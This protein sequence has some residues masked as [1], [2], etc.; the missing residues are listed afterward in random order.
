MPIVSKP[1]PLRRAERKNGSRTHSA[2]PP[3]TPASAPPP[4]RYSGNTQ[5]ENTETPKSA[6]PSGDQSATAPHKCKRTLKIP[7]KFVPKGP[8]NNIRA[9]VQKMALRRSGDKLLSEPTMVI[10]LTYI[11]VT[12]PQWV[13]HVSKNMLAAGMLVSSIKEE[14]S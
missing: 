3:R 9:L 1:L 13:K 11:C 14:I 6:P 12:R 7:L 2:D 10:V 4:H 8:I 5:H